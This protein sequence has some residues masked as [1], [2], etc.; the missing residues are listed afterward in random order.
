MNRRIALVALAV[1]LALVG[2]FAVYKYASNADKRAVA[3]TKATDVLVVQKEIGAGTTW[4]NLVSGGYARQDKVPV[5][6][7]PA[8][9]ITSLA[10]AIP[11]T[12]VATAAI[13]PGQILVREMFGQQ[14][15]VT[16]PL[17]I[18]T[19]KIAV[20][21]AMPGDADVAGFVQYQ[22][23]VA[24]FATYKLAKEAQGNGTGTNLPTGALGGTDLYTTKLLLPRVQVIATSVAATTDVTGK[25]STSP[26]SN[27]NG[28]VLVTLAVTQADAERLILSQQIGQLYLGLLSNDSSTA[29]DTGVIAVGVFNPAPIFVK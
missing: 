24:V 4:A 22:S 6:A 13:A 18:P 5:S 26:G 27:N 25:K 1:L 7:A 15:S 10:A 8:N 3:A 23:E 9:A 11:P 14:T 2:T 16:G 29:A 20:A 21:V 17:P 12:E 19:G 28:S